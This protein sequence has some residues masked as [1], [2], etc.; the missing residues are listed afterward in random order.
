MV[1]V[2]IITTNEL[3]I[4]HNIIKYFISVLRGTFLHRIQF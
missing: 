1:I 2:V 3:N 4:V